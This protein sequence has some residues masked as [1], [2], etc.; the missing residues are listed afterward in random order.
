MTRRGAIRTRTSAPKLAVPK[1][2][3]PTTG[4]PPT[5]VPVTAVPE[6]ATLA[7][8]QLT[9]EQP[10][11]EQPT[12]GK[13]APIRVEL[14]T[15]ID[16][17]PT[18]RGFDVLLRGQ[19]ISTAPVDS[20]SIREASGLEVAM[21]QFGHG[22]EQEAVTMSGEFRNGFQV[23]LP[24]PGGDAIRITD[25]WVRAQSR[26]GAVFET[27]VRLGCMGDQAAILA[28][29]LRET[30]A[31]GAAVG[32][33]VEMPVPRGILYLESATIGKDG[34]LQAHGWTV[35]ASPIVAVQM[36]VDNTRIGAASHGRHR[37]DVAD[38]YPHYPDARHAG[39]TMRK[40]L[41]KP[42]GGAMREGA[43]VTAQ[44]LCLSGACLA[45]TVPLVRLAESSEV[46][47]SG[48]AAQT[49]LLV[50]TGS[51]SNDGERDT[52]G[53]ASVDMV[54]TV[55]EPPAP[56]AASAGVD[57]KRLILV[58]CDKA[59]VTVAGDLLVG[60]WA[61]CGYGIESI[62]IEVDGQQA[63][64]A[65]Y[66]GERADVAAEYPGMPVGTGFLFEQ[67]IPNL[68]AGLHEIRIVASSG[69]GDRK[70]LTVT[71]APP[72]TS[73]FRFELDNPKTRNGVMVHPITGRL[74]IEGWALARD[75]MAG[76][77]VDLDGTLLGQAHYGMARPDVG[78]AFQDWDGGA[79]S[80]YNFHCPSRALPDGD[81]VI[82]ITAR[83]KTGDTHFHA[84]RITVRKTD[85][86]EEAV[87]IR[88]RIK[89]VERSTMTGV[90]DQLHWRPSFHL[91]VA[92]GIADNVTNE[93]SWALTIRS[94]VEQSWSDWRVTMLASGEAEAEAVRAMIERLAHEQVSRFVVI[95]PSEAAAWNAPLV[96]KTDAALAVILAFGDELGRDALAAFAVAS[97]IHSGA[98]CLYADEFRLQPSTARPE[99][100][101]KPDFSPAL[102]LSTN[103]I[104]RPLV[105]RSALLAGTGVTA[106]SLMR[107]G[108]YDLALR[109]TE[110]AG[111]TY[112]VPELLSR[113]DRGAAADPDDGG[114]A[115]RRA[116]ERRGIA[117]DVVPGLAPE[118]W[119]ARRTAPV[120][121]KVS[122]IIPTRGAK[123]YVEI[124]MKTLR[125]VTAYRD[126]EIVCI[127]NIPESESFWK[128]FV[129]EHADKV[130][131]LPAPFN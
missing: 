104:G 128:D 75:G 103:Y 13:P 113:T 84:F 108:F 68:T 15:A 27:G 28:G 96:D 86:P 37:A 79:R 90:L 101:F 1:P 112:H 42:S 38:A 110:A 124:C 130:V 89:W 55:P 77:D 25:M 92:G 64:V 5:G 118:T 70:E 123:G 99:A 119:H 53:P 66:G 127:D 78:Q 50:P 120:S 23:Y 7:P 93:Q 131:D 97:G 114:A 33:A 115:L 16:G 24:M 32:T 48:D 29:P 106:G 94:I 18:H 72:S 88:R 83:S 73:R 81:H 87:S 6:P 62:V 111:E 105:S 61:A 109:C 60:G 51:G 91:I 49:E 107:D 20:F 71:V 11:L 2:G 41:G 98:D 122:I 40:P 125:A 52:S 45:T 80:G 39:F 100:Y 47:Q 117:A 9:L 31:T 116:L 74:V 4:V 126:F 43:T 129:R 12:T 121:G 21:V 3:V 8:E 67:A 65:D 17:W 19:I 44:V 36:F 35:T 82:G 102:L 14:D 46:E 30:D 26:D 34:H 69:A 57:P 10:R 85:N 76:I 22:D 59:L 56:E 54:A 95:D 58:I 63:G